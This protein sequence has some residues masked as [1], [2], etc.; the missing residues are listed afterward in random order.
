MIR[1]QARTVH[2]VASAGNDAFVWLAWPKERMDR[3]IGRGRSSYSWV[4]SHGGITVFGLAE[5]EDETLAE[6]STW[7]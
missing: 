2:E 4:V 3:E 7:R 5:Y 1:L 6:A